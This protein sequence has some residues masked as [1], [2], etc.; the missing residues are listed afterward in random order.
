MKKTIFVVIIIVILVGAG[1]GLWYV[2]RGGEE[3]NTNVNGDAAVAENKNITVQADYARFQDET[4]GLIFEYPS[5]WTS[6]PIE[7]LEKSLTPEQNQK[8]NFLLYVVHPGNAVVMASYTQYSIADARKLS[9]EIEQAVTDLKQADPDLVT[10]KDES[11]AEDWSCEVRFTAQGTLM[12]VAS[13]T[14]HTQNEF[15]DRFITVE[16]VAPADVYEN[17]REIADY[18]INS[19]EK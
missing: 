19:I 3:T 5:N 4:T 2:M 7:E 12:Q 1:F 13:Y 15:Y 10:I 17:Y 14:F 6:I 11:T 16:L 18:V 9:D 8:A